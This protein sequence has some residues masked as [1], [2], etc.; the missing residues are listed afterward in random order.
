[1]LHGLAVLLQGRP[2]RRD[3]RAHVRRRLVELF[4]VV[5]KVFTTQG[6]PGIPQGGRV[7]V[8]HG[9][10]QTGLAPALITRRPE[11]AAQ[12]V[13]NGDGYHAIASSA[14]CCAGSS[15]AR[16]GPE[17]STSSSS[18]FKGSPLACQGR[19]SRRWTR[20]CVPCSSC[21]SAITVRNTTPPTCCL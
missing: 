1:R 17:S 13:A 3:R 9:E 8:T 11:P 12:V 14:S 18:E 15:P 5:E 2:D 21:D 7:R 16:T 10:R 20:P 4:R 6:R 19:T